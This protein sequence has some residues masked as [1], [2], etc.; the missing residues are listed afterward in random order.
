MVIAFDETG[1]MIQFP[2][3]VYNRNQVVVFKVRISKSY[4][5]G[6]VNSLFT[7]IDSVYDYFNDQPENRFV[8]WSLFGEKDSTV[9][10]WFYQLGLYKGIRQE[11]KRNNAYNLSTYSY[12]GKNSIPENAEK[13]NLFPLQVFFKML[14]EKQFGIR[15][16]DRNFF[17]NDTIS[18]APLPE[19]LDA[20]SDDCY[21]W[22]SQR[23]TLGSL[24]GKHCTECNNNIQFSL[25]K[26][27]P[28]QAT[29]L[30]WYNQQFKLASSADSIKGEKQLM[31]DLKY[32]L[33][34][35]KIL[36][37]IDK[38]N[39]EG[40]SAVK[41]WIDTIST[42]LNETG[43]FKN[44]EA[45]KWERIQKQRLPLFDSS[46]MKGS[47]DIKNYLAVLNRVKPWIFAWLWYNK[48]WLVINPLP[49][50]NN[51]PDS[52]K[53]KLQAQLKDSNRILQRLQQQ[54]KFMDSSR[55]HVSPAIRNF[56]EFT[57]VQHITDSIKQLIDIA[58][59]NIK[60]INN[61]LD[62]FNNSKSAAN[63]AKAALGITSFQT[64]TGQLPVFGH[65]LWYKKRWLFP[66]KITIMKQFSYS[67][68]KQSLSLIHRNE[69]QRSMISEIPENEKSMMVI[70]NIPVK[71]KIN[72]SHTLGGYKDMEEFT[73]LFQKLLQGLDSTGLLKLALAG[74]LRNISNFILDGFSR[75]AVGLPI[76]AATK[77]AGVFMNEQGKV[78]IM[79]ADYLIQS[80]KNSP[81]T[82]TT[83]MSVLKNIT[84]KT[85]TTGGYISSFIPLPDSTAPYMVN[86][87]IIIDSTKFKTNLKVGALH[88]IQFAAGIALVRNPVQQTNIDTTGSGFKTSSSSNASSAIVG[89]KIYP[90]RA[91][92]RDGSLLPRY[93]LRRL[94]VVAAMAIP[95]P[96]NNFYLGGGYDIVP[97]LTYT[98]GWNLYKQNYYQVQNGAVIKSSARYAN[99]GMYQ[100]V[101]IN[102]VVFVEFI[103]LFFN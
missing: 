73:I 86:S 65:T 2:K 38:K 9:F 8:L 101:T 33:E 18:L 97:G 35:G 13:L 98:V 51:P 39:E 89:I 77:K 30:E 5:S 99:G 25:V 28:L 31:K 60:K 19:Q 23:I 46:G 36:A 56:G 94:S 88:R 83:N 85:D 11:L 42:L 71:S 53:T 32:L 58:E 84:P 17:I 12:K 41:N 92:L 26:E 54:E 4:F 61:Q 91:Y 52:I 103:K 16:Y 82:L 27:I 96:L 70:H 90:A 81:V 68:N 59:E 29:I 7:K 50:T 14:I 76:L 69:R 48:G 44:E 93:P 49:I 102:P 67:D 10:K 66:G 43:T 62:E 55:V 79:T 6:Q 72:I 63:A 95:K 21:W 100:G 40:I 34:A 20:D 45:A 57:N 1:K 24:I 3:Q 47:I 37:S 75:D 80:A 15:T 78:D 64:Y 87:T 74:P 22:Y